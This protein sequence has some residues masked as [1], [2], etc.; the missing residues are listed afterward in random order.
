MSPRAAARAARPARRAG[1]ARAGPGRDRARRRRRRTSRSAARSTR[2]PPRAR[3]RGASARP[4]SSLRARRVD[5][6][7]RAR[8]GAT[9]ARAPR[10]RRVAAGEQQRAPRARWASAVAP[11][12]AELRR[13]GLGARDERLRGVDPPVGELGARDRLRVGGAAQ[14]GGIASISASSPRGC[15]PSV[16]LDDARAARAPSSRSGPRGPRPARPRAPRRARASLAVAARDRDVGGGAEHPAGDV[17]VGGDLRRLQRVVLER[18]RGRDVALAQQAQRLRAGEH[19]HEL[20]LPGGARDG[21][22]A[23]GVADRVVVA[24]DQVLRPR[25]PVERVEVARERLVVGRVQVRARRASASAR[26]AAHVAGVGARVRERGRGRRRSAAGR[27]AAARPP[28]PARSARS[29][30][31]RRARRTRPAICANRTVRASAE[32]RSGERVE[33]GGEP[34]VRRLVAAEEVLGRGARGD[35]P[36]AGATSLAGTSV[37]RLA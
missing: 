23:R 11:R 5:R 29:P 21:D 9:P 27:R 4:A 30:R 35:Q 28:A 12:E 1:A 3:P 34:P 31:R 26:A 18:E 19:R 20:V 8:R 6:R 13:G 36:D 16:A 33:R 14:L 17:V 22:P 10:P 25:Q 37:E 2:T 7:A 32:S 15:S 24:L